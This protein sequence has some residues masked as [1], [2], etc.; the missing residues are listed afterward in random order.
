MDATHGS[1]GL[2]DGFSVELPVLMDT[3]I[4]RMLL[5][6]HPDDRP[7][8]L[9]HHSE[10]PRRLIGAT[11]P[12]ST[13]GE[14]SWRVLT[15]VQLGEGTHDLQCRAVKIVD[16]GPSACTKDVVRRG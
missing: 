1:L 2:L 12:G 14:T 6:L 4:D 9:T 8:T 13:R 11:E 10:P 16:P 15:T 3:G 7:P 5:W